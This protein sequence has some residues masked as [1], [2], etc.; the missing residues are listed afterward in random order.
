MK[1]IELFIFDMDGLLIETGRLAYRAYLKS[2]Q[3]HDYELVKE[4]YY[5]LTGQTEA[6][7]RKGMSILYG[8][9][10]PSDE[11][12]DSTNQFKAEIVATEGRVYTKTG[13]AEILQFAREQNVLL[14]LA[15]SNQR[16]KIEEYLKLE[17]LQDYF[18]IIVS[19][20]DVKEGKPTGEIFLKAC[21][22]AAVS[23]SDSLVFEDSIVGIEAAKNAGI[24]SVLIKDHLIGLPDYHGKNKLQLDVKQL[25][26][27][28]PI[29]DYE[30][31]DLG[32]AQKF[33]E[34]KELYL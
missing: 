24:R 18:T 31:H 30:F 14:A 19:G 33:L 17:G 11:W 23:P 16:I 25:K 13:V 32:Q 9:E 21:E 6:G 4:V 28:L 12:R 7:I 15:S 20:D 34:K 1:K 3:K 10:V 5:L 29:P 8:S 27:E 2:A 26:K 22:Q